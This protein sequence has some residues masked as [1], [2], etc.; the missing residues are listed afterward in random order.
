M[1]RYPGSGGIDNLVF[2]HHGGGGPNP[3]NAPGALA[4]LALLALGA[5]LSLRRRAK[6][7]R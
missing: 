3:V 5:V 7:C 4:L 2:R 6:R 1:V